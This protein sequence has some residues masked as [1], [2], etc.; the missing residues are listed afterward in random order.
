[1]KCPDPGDG[2]GIVSCS[3]TLEQDLY[4]LV[5]SGITAF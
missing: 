5:A 2:S 4:R 3:Q 1:M